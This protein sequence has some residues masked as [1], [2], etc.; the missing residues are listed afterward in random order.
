MVYTFGSLERGFESDGTLQYY[1]ARSQAASLLITEFH[2]V[3]QSG[4]PCYQTGY[5]VQL[6]VYSDFYIGEESV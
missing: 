4:G 5:P 2:Y 3:S 1:G 6:G